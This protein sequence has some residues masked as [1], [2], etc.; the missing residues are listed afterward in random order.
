MS[1]GLIAQSINPGVFFYWT[2]ITTTVPN[3]VVT[4]TQTN[5]STNNSALFKVHQGWDRLY[6]GDCSSYKT[7]T[8]I[9]G[10]TGASFTVPTPGDYIIGIKYDSKS[11]AGTTAPVPA[12]IIFNFVTSLGGSTA[13]SVKLT[14]Q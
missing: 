5:T 7:G 11:I 4:V 9:A 3:Q 6:Q 1:G 2:H 12:N 10:G 8:Q 13:A 14:K